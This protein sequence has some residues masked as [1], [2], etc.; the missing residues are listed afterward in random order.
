[1]TAQPKESTKEFLDRVD[2]E[3]DET[4]LT[5]EDRAAISRRPS[6]RAA[7]MTIAETA[8]YSV[9]VVLA[10]VRISSIVVGWVS[11]LAFVA[12]LLGATLGM[13]A[14]YWAM[15]SISAFAINWIIMQIARGITGERA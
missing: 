9:A 3:H 5:D 11:A 7:L 14:A 6:G 13:T 10:L 8:I 15:L 12:V 1:M 4:A 2:A